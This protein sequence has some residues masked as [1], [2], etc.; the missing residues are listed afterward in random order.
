MESCE[1]S[2]RLTA[3]NRAA[4]GSSTSSGG[5]EF[6]SGGDAAAAYEGAGVD[7]S[8]D[9]SGG[10]VVGVVDGDATDGAWAAGAGLTGRLRN[11][12]REGTLLP[13][14]LE[15]FSVRPVHATKE[16]EELATR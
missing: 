1:A 8:G 16:P 13:S 7:A 6:L 14:P 4:I 15:T 9:I 10:A 2:S 3:F 5:G 12:G 11:G